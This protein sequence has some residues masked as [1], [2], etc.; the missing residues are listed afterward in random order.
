[1]SPAGPP[2]IPF[3][4]VVMPAYN[5]QASIRRVVLEHAALLKRLEGMAAEWEIVVVDDASRDDTARILEALRESVPRLRVVRHERNQGI[6][7]SFS[8]CYAEAR[9]TH[10]YA[11]GSDGQWPAENLAA[12]LGCLL[13]GADL[14]VGVRGNRREIY[15]LPR[16][17]VSFGFNLLP[18]V[19]FGVAVKDAGSVKLGVREAFACE[20]ISRSPF[21]EAERIVRARRSGLKVGFVPIRFLARAGGKAGGAG[22]R[23][24]VFSLRDVARCVKAYGLR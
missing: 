18:A 9:G 2:P 23:N 8:R 24:I 17:I 7:A 16:R 15:S 6:F 13:A 22:W 11:T 12:L 21:F 3:L 1:L 14:V 19:L 10:V 4:S 5:E 20:L